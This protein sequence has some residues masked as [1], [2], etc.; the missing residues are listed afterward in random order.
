MVELHIFTSGTSGWWDYHIYDKCINEILHKGLG[1]I[2]IIR[3]E[4]LN[5]ILN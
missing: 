5:S 2:D 3:E 1:D 4:K